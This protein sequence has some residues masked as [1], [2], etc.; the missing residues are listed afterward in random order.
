MELMIMIADTAVAITVRLA[1]KLEQP[2][3][4]Q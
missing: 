2:R 3:Q 1:A 4:M